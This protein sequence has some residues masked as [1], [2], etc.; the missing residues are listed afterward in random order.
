MQFDDAGCPGGVG[1]GKDEVGLPGD[2]LRRRGGQ[3]VAGGG[4]RPAI[5]GIGDRRHVVWLAE[6][7]GGE[8]RR[9]DEEVLLGCAVMVIMVTD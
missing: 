1:D 3:I 6:L 5:G 9:G 8:P 2:G 7:V 4:E